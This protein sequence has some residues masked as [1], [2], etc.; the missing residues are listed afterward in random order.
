MNESQGND[1]IDLV[2]ASSSPA[3]IHRRSC[4]LLLFKLASGV[5]L[6]LSTA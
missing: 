2:R 1:A 4:G 6:T 5:S 3:H